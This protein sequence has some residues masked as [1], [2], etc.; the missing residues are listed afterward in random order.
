METSDLRFLLYDETKSVTGS[1]QPTSTALYDVTLVTRES[2]KQNTSITKCRG[3]TL[4]LTRQN[5][6]CG[7]HGLRFKTTMIAPSQSEY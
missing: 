1:P 3:I 7:S 5:V 2:T 6:S 4:H